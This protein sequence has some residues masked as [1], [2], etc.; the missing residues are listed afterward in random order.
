MTNPYGIGAEPGGELERVAAAM[1]FAET[2]PTSVGVL[3]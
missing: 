1:E 2:A 3:E